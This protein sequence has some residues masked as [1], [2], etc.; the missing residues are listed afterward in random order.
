MIRPEFR[1]RDVRSFVLR[2]GRV[3]AS[4]NKALEQYWPRYGLQVVDGA[5]DFERLLGNSR[6]VVLEIGYG[7]G[8]SLLQMAQQ[9]ADKNFI[10]VEVHPPG[11][12]RLINEAARL[13]LTNLRTYCAD[14]LDV[15]SLCI[16]DASLE[17]VQLYFPDPWHKKRHHKRRIVQAD[18]ARC[19]ASKLRPGGVFHLCTDWVP[20]A[21]HMSAVLRQ[22]PTL[23]N[24]STDGDYVV[25]PAWRPETKFE[26][27]G[28]RLGHE[29]RDLVYRR[30]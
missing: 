28:L 11:V 24:Q 21:E 1:R 17:R 8:D 3:T 27:R 20:Y 15:L 7:M 18:F 19:V 30:A 5:L 6:P 29:V 4:Q 23:E 2:T 22:I 9:E 13:G 16:P 10:G 25:R 26:R 14:A 12:G